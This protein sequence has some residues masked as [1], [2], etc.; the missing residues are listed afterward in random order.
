M[1]HPTARPFH[2]W[3]QTLVLHKLANLPRHCAEI[4]E[5]WFRNFARPASAL[6]VALADAMHLALRAAWWSSQ[7][8]PGA[9]KKTPGELHCLL[10][11]LFVAEGIQCFFSSRVPEWL[12]WIGWGLGCG[13]SRTK[14]C[15]DKRSYI[16]IKP[17]RLDLCSMRVAAR[18]VIPGRPRH[19]PD[20]WHCRHRKQK[21]WEHMQSMHTS[22]C[23]KNFTDVEDRQHS[24]KNS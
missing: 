5:M 22:D 21:C 16:V 13:I 19:S 10:L 12:I 1:E 8:T 11:R 17:N 14:R 7:E 4:S 20:L 23:T 15:K 2:P 3:L 18:C 24:Q 6:C 9:P